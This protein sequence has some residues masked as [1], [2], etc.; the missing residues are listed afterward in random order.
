[1][2]TNKAT[3]VATLDWGLGKVTENIY[4]EFLK[5]FKQDGNQTLFVVLVFCLA[6]EYIMLNQ[7]NTSY[8]YCDQRC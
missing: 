8:R 6:C 4:C 7:I 5:L 3:L 2:L 1:M